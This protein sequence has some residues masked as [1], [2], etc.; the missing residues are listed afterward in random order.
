MFL[1]EKIAETEQ[2]PSNLLRNS[3]PN[4]EHILIIWPGGA[5]LGLGTSKSFGLGIRS[6]LMECPTINPFRRTPRPLRF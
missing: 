6:Y 4:C 1:T 3:L 5:S 2:R